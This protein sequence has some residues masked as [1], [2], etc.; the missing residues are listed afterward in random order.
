M[1]IIFEPLTQPY[2]LTVFNWLDQPFIQ[3]FWDN[4]SE[5]RDDIINF[6]QGRPTPSPFYDGA[7]NY[8]LGLVQDSQ[9]KIP[10]CL[11]LTASLEK[12]AG[13]F[14]ANRG[15]IISLDFAIGNPDYLG[16]G[17]AAPTL[18]QFMDFYHHKI[19][20][21]IDM[22]FIDPDINNAKAIHVYR[23][24]GFKLKG[25]YQVTDGFFAG[26]TNLIMIKKYPS[27]PHSVNA[28]QNPQSASHHA[29][30]KTNNI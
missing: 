12:W 1:A 19:D 4:S 18:Q 10:F 14:L 3:E 22:F 25:Q 21:T 29:A 16:Q 28:N 30:P 7:F 26:H 15:K 24:A 2:L 5:H 13:Q 11:V 8:W 17:L 9:D 23:K 6:V 27:E 20:P